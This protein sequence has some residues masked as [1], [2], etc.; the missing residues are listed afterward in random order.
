[1]GALFEGLEGEELVAVVLVL[2]S[3]NPP[4]SMSIYTFA[5]EQACVFPTAE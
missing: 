2:I 3:G 4:F 5:E 1:M